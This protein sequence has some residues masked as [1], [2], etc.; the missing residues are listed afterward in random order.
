LARA[1]PDTGSLPICP[2]PVKIAAELKLEGSF[3]NKDFQ[4]D[5][6]LEVITICTENKIIFF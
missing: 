2:F 5:R 3:Q 6:F 4:F 1:T